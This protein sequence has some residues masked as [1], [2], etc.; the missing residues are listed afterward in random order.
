MTGAELRA[1]AKPWPKGRSFDDFERGQRFEHHWG[2]TLS[3]ADSVLFSTLTLHYNPTYFNV[4][5]AREQGHR[6]LVINP[7][8][9]FLTV[10]GLSVEDLSEGGG[11]FLGVNDLTFHRQLNPG[12]TVSARSEVL[13]VRDSTSRPEV[14]IVTWHTEGRDQRDEIVVDFERSNMIRRRGVAT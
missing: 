6:D 8:L 2:R 12:D 11:A 7:L 5:Y 1:R 14:G 9:V 3:E 10:F 13:D 4:E